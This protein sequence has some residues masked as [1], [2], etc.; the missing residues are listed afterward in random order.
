MEYLD[1]I[2]NGETLYQARLDEYAKQG[3]RI[4]P[5]KI[6][7]SGWLVIRVVTERQHTYRIASTAPYYFEV[8]G[9]PRISR[10]AVEYFTRWLE[11]SAK[12]IEQGDNASQLS[13]APFVQ[14]AR[15]FWQ[16]RLTQATR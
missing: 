1:V 13:A 7:E 8:A 4:P 11:K 6:E 2:F 10:S 3:G 12:Q 9:Q 5:L 14:A 16:Q 15:E